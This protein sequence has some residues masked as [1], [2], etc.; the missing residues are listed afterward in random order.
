MSVAKRNLNYRL[1]WASVIYVAFIDLKP[2]NV[3]SESAKADARRVRGAAHAWIFSSNREPQSFLWICECL[4]IDPEYL[5][6]MATTR[7]GI[8]KVLNQ[9]GRDKS[10]VEVQYE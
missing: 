2:R 3:K 1:L 7:E 5:R 10:T 8:K 9:G 4:D 6:S